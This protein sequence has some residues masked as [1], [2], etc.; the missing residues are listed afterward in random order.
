MRIQKE[1]LRKLG[2]QL[3]IELTDKELEQIGSSISDITD[4]LEEILLVDTKGLEGMINNMEKDFSFDAKDAK[5]VGDNVDMKKVN[6]FNGEYVVLN[7]EKN[8]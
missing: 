4:K 5:D 3:K 2:D 7:K 6:N 8:E 1:E